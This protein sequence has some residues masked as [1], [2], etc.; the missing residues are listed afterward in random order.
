MIVDY[1]AYTIVPAKFGEFLE[2]WQSTALKIQIEHGGKFLGFFLT[3]TGPVNTILHLWAYE[4]AADRETRRRTFEA[5][6]EW[7]EY[8]RRLDELGALESVETR[9]MRPAPFVEFTW[10]AVSVA[11]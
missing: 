7:K 8:R 9:L 11:A 3:D 5:L 2:L 4:D 6:P 10:P 1:R